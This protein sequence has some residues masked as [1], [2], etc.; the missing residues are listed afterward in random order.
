[1]SRLKKLTLKG[2]EAYKYR[3]D[4]YYC[5]LNPLWNRQLEMIKTDLYGCYKAELKIH[6]QTLRDIIE[7]TYSVEKEFREYLTRKAI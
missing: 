3:V 7:Q 4:A 2:M 5:K 6:E 1:M